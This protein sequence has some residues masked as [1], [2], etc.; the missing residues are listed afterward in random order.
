MFR[1]LILIFLIGFLSLTASLN[2]YHA[3]LDDSKINTTYKTNAF[4]A[5]VLSNNTFDYG[6]NFSSPEM[7]V[8]VHFYFP[9]TDKKVPLIIISH[10]AGGIFQFHHNYKDI[11][12]S[13]DYAV[14]IIDHFSPRGIA[15]DF[16]FIKVTEAMMLSDVTAALNYAS[17]HYDYRIDGRIGYIGW[18][19]G[20][21]SSLSL[22]NKKIFNKYFPKNLNLSFIA[23]MY[24][25]CDILHEDYQS[26]EIPVF[27]ISGEKD[28]ITPSRHCKK[29]YEDFSHKEDIIYYGLKDAHHGFDN[30]AFLLGAYLPWQPILLESQEC[31]IIIGRTLETTNSTKNYSLKD[32]VSRERY[33]DNCTQKG[34]YVK[35]KTDAMNEAKKL[36]VSYVKTKLPNN[37]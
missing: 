20:G 14:A 23:G 6:S 19:K 25:F 13:D 1:I 28:T 21:I 18:S 33:I 22:R 17:K 32:Y 11:F 37:D 9:E 15:I 34:A 2:P 7:S 35:Y 8:P 3:C 30:H 36:L 4:T 31:R 29:L 10:G 16:D 5:C 24:T 27:L 12:L 26:S